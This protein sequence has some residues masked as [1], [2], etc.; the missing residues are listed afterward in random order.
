MSHAKW[1]Y[2]MIYCRG[3][4]D[5]VPIWVLLADLFFQSKIQEVAKRLGYEVQFESDPE[6]FL[7]KTKAHPPKLVL[8]DLTLDKKISLSSFFKKFYE[9]ATSQDVSVVGYTTHVDWKQTEPIHSYCEQVLTKNE[10]VQN[11]PN[12]MLGHLKRKGQ[13]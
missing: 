6:K 13:P 7:E 8:I 4:T 2:F 12:L 9:G 10:F 11:L 1:D 5:T 3:M